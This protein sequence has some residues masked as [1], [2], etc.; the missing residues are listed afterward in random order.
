MKVVPTSC[1]F[2]LHLRL[3]FFFCSNS[4]LTF[5]DFLVIPFISF[6]THTENEGCTREMVQ[7]I[8]AIGFL[9]ARKICENVCL[10]SNSRALCLHAWR[11]IEENVYTKLSQRDFSAMEISLWSLTRPFVCMNKVQ[12]ILFCHQRQ[13]KNAKKD[14]FMHGKLT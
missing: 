2:F 8:A 14:Y 13:K 9:C 6:K 1:F 3:S 11:E 10:Q 7:D 4:I 12:A 5:V